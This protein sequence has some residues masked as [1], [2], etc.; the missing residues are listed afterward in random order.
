MGDFAKDEIEIETGSGFLL[1]LKI[2]ML[3]RPAVITSGI[4]M[5][6][7]EPHRVP[8][9]KRTFIGLFY[10]YSSTVI[11]IPIKSRLNFGIPDR[12]LE[13][14]VKDS[15]SGLHTRVWDSG[16]NFSIW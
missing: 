16:L 4:L 12:G 1:V 2:S 10:I 3:Y 6:R 14:K 15:G 11:G 13:L 5:R 9:V 8:A 7:L